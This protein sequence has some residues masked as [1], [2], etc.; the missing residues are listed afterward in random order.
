MLD[1]LTA[2]GLVALAELGD[3]SQLLALAQATRFRAWQVLVGIAVAAA[4]LLGAAT[5]IGGALGAVTHGPWLPLVAGALFLGFAAWALREARSL[6]A[7]EV[8]ASGG[9]DGGTPDGGTIAE[10]G[11]AASRSALATVIGAFV[12]AELGDKTMLATATLAAAAAPIPTWIGATAGMTLSGGAAIAVGRW[13][14]RSLPAR[15]L[16]HAS[17]AAFALFGVLLLIDGLRAW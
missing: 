15:R 13:L 11:R 17:A 10:T 16:R 6:D 1:L 12:L 14:H 9:P 4:L 2:F 3:K 8:D 7:A 5:A